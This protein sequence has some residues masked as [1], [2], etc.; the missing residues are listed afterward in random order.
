MPRHDVRNDGMGPFAVFYCD[1]CDRE[2]RTQPDVKNTIA[3]DLG[4]NAVGNLLR[5]VPLFGGELA[6]SVVGE[7]PRYVMSLTADQLQAHWNQVKDR[8]SECP[9]CSR[10]V[11][12]SCFDTQSGFCNDDSPRANEVNEARGEQAGAALKGL[13]SAFGLGDSFKPLGDAMRQAGRAAEQAS[14]SMARCPQDGTLAEAGTK[15]CP[16]CGSPMVQPQAQL[17][18]KCGADTKGAKFCPECGTKM[19]VKPAGICPSCGA[20]TKGAKF[21]P[22]CGTK[23]T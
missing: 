15:F 7:D 1:C 6:N 17:C 19:D 14:Q 4:R 22:E 5:K 11:C 20:E 21:C 23:Q 9:T 2:Y 3:N 18:P 8:F 16:E 10:V 13:A 12:V